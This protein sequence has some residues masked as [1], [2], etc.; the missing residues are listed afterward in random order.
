M[1]VTRFKTALESIF[2]VLRTIILSTLEMGQLN[3][4]VVFANYNYS[5]PMRGTQ[6]ASRI[7]VQRV[8]TI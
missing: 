7:I 5:L 2:G 1:C 6:L 4:C 3:F 8:A